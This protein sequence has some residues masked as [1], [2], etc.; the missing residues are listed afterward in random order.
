MH[1]RPTEQRILDL[2]SDGQ[3]HTREEIKGLLDDE[4]ADM[5]TVRI[6]VSNLRKKIAAKG[7]NVVVSRQTVDGKVVTRY[8]LMRVLASPYDGK[9]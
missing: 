5:V 1:L 6:H 4:L 7:E 2:L 9:T 3:R 8:Q